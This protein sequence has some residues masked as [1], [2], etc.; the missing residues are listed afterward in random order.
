[1]LLTIC[2]R[3]AVRAKRATSNKY[4]LPGPTAST[5]RSAIRSAPPLAWIAAD[6]G[7][8]APISTTI[9]QETAR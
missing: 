4:G 1:V 3:A 7:I 5:I 6:S 9:C 8:S 2:P